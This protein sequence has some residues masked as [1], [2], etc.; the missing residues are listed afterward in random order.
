LKKELKRRVQAEQT[1]ER[2]FSLKPTDGRD[3]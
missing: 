2:V 1:R 3:I